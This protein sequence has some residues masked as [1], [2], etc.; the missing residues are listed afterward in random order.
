MNLTS[1]RLL[2]EIFAEGIISV[3]IGGRQGPILLDKLL[4]FHKA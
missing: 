2:G 1:V 4:K 3:D